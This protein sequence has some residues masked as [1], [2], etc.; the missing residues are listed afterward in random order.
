MWLWGSRRRAASELDVHVE[1]A[2]VAPAPSQPA[3]PEPEPPAGHPLAD[4]VGSLA[5]AL[6]AHRARAED[7]RASNRALLAVTGR[8]LELARRGGFAEVAE[9]L[10]RTSTGLGD[11]VGEIVSATG[12]AAAAIESYAGS[13]RAFEA[14]LAELNRQVGEI[15][16][17][18]AEIRGIAD[19]TKLLA[20][21]ARI[22]AARAGAAGVGFQ[23]VA[24]EVGSL[25]V[26]TR[27]VVS[28]VVAAAD[29]IA[30]AIGRG[31]E[32][33]GENLE[34]L[35]GAEAAVRV[36][37]GAAVET[38]GRADALLEPTGR[39]Q[40]LAYGQV[41]LQE[42]VEQ[43]RLHGEHVD[44]AASALAAE[45]AAGA[46]AGDALWLEAAPAPARPAIRSLGA[47]EAAFER[48]L[49]DDRPDDA[50][51]AL[52]Q[53]LAADV[54]PDE[55]LGRLAGAAQRAYNAAGPGR[56]T[57]EHFRNARILE[58]A[59]ERLEPLVS[60]GRDG[61]P[62]VIGNAWQDFHD[63]GRRIVVAAL[64]A[65]G[66]RVVDLGLSVRNEDLVDAAVREGATV[67][68]VS[69]L[70]L[71]T[72]KHVPELKEL[73]RRRGLHRIRVIAGGAPFLVDPTLRERV[74]AD[75]VAF[76]PAGAVRLVRHLT[77][78][79]AA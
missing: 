60:D 33:F 59:L 2:P 51:R 73:L 78:G 3:E 42:L 58:A 66:F 62:I 11:A 17:R 14:E 76:D 9:R 46:R 43:A 68:G 29:R 79:Q 16:E 27:E 24:E 26:T 23:V 13:I 50:A 30:E 22:E 38:D 61:P 20:L 28:D 4:G 7:A 18:M 57:I 34:A 45:L 72:A 49:V 31:A 47:F 48:A 21:N 63:L 6:H 74:G 35:A 67:I 65:D 39:V 53:A 41:E 25:S 40:E 71:H 55:L 69:T 37:E 1:P 15:H 75:G 44:Q 32:R 10:S 56:P 5:R 8:A 64:R 36:L 54:A 12:H 70:L 77:L 52:E 19:R